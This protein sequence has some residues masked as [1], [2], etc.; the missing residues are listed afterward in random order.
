MRL[1]D[2]RRSDKHG[3]KSDILK[4]IGLKAVWIEVDSR[5]YPLNGPEIEW[6]PRL[7]PEPTF[8]T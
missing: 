5:H 3:V 2:C 4:V 7:R 6:L 1:L 8:E